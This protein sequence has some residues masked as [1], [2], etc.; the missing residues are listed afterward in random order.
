MTMRI[1]VISDIHGNLTALEAVIADLRDASPDLVLHGGDLVYGGA[2]P[3]EVVDRICDLGWLG[4]CGNT[5]EM[6]WAPEG[7]HELAAKSP[8][9]KP[10][11]T[12]FEEMIPTINARLGDDRIRWLK[13]LPYAQ[14]RDAVALVHASSNNLWRGPMPEASDTELCETFAC[15]DAPVAVY[16]HIH[17]PFVRSLPTMT[18]ANT[19]SV[20]LSYDGDCRASYVVVE[21]KQATIRRVEYDV[22]R[23]VEVLLQSGL[24]HAEWVAQTLRAGHFVPPE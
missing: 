13:T 24:P 22:E 6:L 2:R 9:L 20:S 14:R 19:G 16:G 18:V 15:L 12:R 23:E 1:A 5:D 11:F 7:L 8:K 21:D 10:L 3:A 4:V 17:R